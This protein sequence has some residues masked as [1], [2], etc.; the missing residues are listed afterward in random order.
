MTFRHL[1]NVGVA[2]ASLLLCPAALAQEATNT[3]STVEVSAN[4]N[5][6]DERQ[7]ASNS[8]I[9][10]QHDEITQYGDNNLT[11]VLKRIPSISVGK[12]NEIRMRGLGNGYT[13]ILIN[14]E[15]AS[16][17]FSIDSLSPE[18]IERIEILRTATAEYSTQAIAGSINIVLRNKV[19]QAQRE[20]KIGIGQS[21]GLLSPSAV[22]Q[23]S[24]RFDDISYVIAG[25]I[26]KQQRDTPEVYL[27]TVS[28]ATGNINTERNTKQDHHFVQ[29]EINFAPRLVWQLNEHDAITWQNFFGAD[30]RTDAKVRHETSPTNTPSALPEN[31]SFW[32]AHT[33]NLRSDLKLTSQLA[34]EAKLDVNVG[35]KMTRRHTEFDFQGFDPQFNLKE[36]H[37]VTSGIH[38]N[39]ATLNG[40]YHAPFVENHAIVIG[41]DGNFIRR[42]EDRIERLS[43]RNNLTIANLDESYHA[44]VTRLALYAQDEWDFTQAWN[45]SIGLR[46]EGLR[47]A[48]EGNVLSQVDNRSSV[49]SP[50]IQATWEIAPKKQWRFG[51][52]R[53]YK[54]P[55]TMFLIPRRYTVD[56]NNSP[57]NSDTQGNP[58]LRPELAWGLDAAYEHYFVEGGVFSVSAFSRRIDDVIL[59][60]LSQ[61][62]STWINSPVND[63][64]ASVKGIG[65]ELKIPLQK[66]WDNAPQLTLSGNIN[67]NWSSVDHVPPPANR[68]DQ[69]PAVTANFAADYLYNE[70]WSAGASANTVQGTLVR[71][72]A[73][74][75]TQNNNQKELDAYLVWK[76]NKQTQLRFTCAN[77]LHPDA[78]EVDQFR[79]DQLGAQ[80]RRQLEIQGTSAITFRMQFE[81]QF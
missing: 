69:Q 10:V 40:K 75:T 51:L 22:L 61:H 36:R 17:N 20:L 67:R 77:L 54:A 60:E 39:T 28:D 37:E 6:I 64:E 53:T 50:L 9:I 27:E 49:L 63:G 58:N 35:I 48:T 81:Y 15:P 31:H 78:I 52:S 43:D 12:G 8:K 57:L 2:I 29:D 5:V 73:F 4:K 45:A 62:G 3:I 14:G 65:I 26:F 23:L 7:H 68:L 34:N 47:T 24:D 21:R 18:L 76:T 74:L 19:L 66:I 33:T 41:W 13:Q 79:N 71:N 56:N 1:C 25:T 80:S 55:T 30:H 46:W 11:D 59:T 16:P 44:T 70:H 32:N 38:D 42:F 72:S